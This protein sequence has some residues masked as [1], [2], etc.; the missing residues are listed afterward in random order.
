M[1]HKQTP[2]QQIQQQHYQHQQSQQQLQEQSNC[3]Q[4]QQK[5]EKQQQPQQNHHNQLQQRNATRAY[6]QANGQQHQ[7]LQGEPQEKKIVWEGELRWEESIMANDG[8]PLSC[9]NK[10]TRIVKCQAKASKG[11]SNIQSWPRSLNIQLIHRD[12]A[13]T[14]NSQTK[15]IQNSRSVIF[16][17]EQSE[18]EK[19]L[20][21]ALSSTYAA[22]VHFSGK[23]PHHRSCAERTSCDNFSVDL[24]LILDHDGWNQ[25]IAV[26][27]LS[28]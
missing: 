16:Y 8:T 22:L 5:Q 18:S 12:V 2:Q 27:V 24:V 19:A 14:V 1:Q 9:G 23:F 26:L 10:I 13:R 3:E 28:A 21:Q 20:T 7:T 11:D 25:K 6:H 4:Q 17:P 15:F